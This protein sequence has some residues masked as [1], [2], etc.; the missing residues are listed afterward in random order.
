MKKLLKIIKISFVHT[1]IRLFNN[2][3][4]KGKLNISI[5]L[6]LQKEIIKS[7]FTDEN[8]RKIS[9]YH[10]TCFDKKEK[11]RRIREPKLKTSITHDI[12][13]FILFSKVA[14]SFLVFESLPWNIESL[15]YAKSFEKTIGKGKSNFGG[16]EG[17]RKKGRSGRGRG[18]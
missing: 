13:L 3:A 9:R 11:L 18:S 5:H 7:R 8:P 14:C 12:R 1:F 6:Q 10:Q 2:S 15:A 16:R 17:S 4:S